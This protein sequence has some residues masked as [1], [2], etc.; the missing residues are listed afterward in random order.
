[1]GDTANSVAALGLLAAGLIGYAVIR[2]PG[3][4]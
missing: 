4:S 3:L 2:R 1:M